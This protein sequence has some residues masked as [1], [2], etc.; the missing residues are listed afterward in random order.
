LSAHLLQIH[1]P[2]LDR[3]VPGA[4]PESPATK[5]CRN[6]VMTQPR[7]GALTNFARA[8]LPRFRPASLVWRSTLFMK[9]VAALLRRTGPQAEYADVWNRR[10][11]LLNALPARLCR[12]CN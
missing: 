7:T 12:H 8:A 6:V 3:Y 4:R 9:R 1:Q 2:H 10:V 5:S 11:D